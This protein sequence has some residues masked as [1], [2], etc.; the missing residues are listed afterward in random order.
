MRMRCS[1]AGAAQARTVQGVGGPGSCPMAAS[2]R[3]GLAGESWHE[4]HPCCGGPA[5]E[6]GSTRRACKE[7]RPVHELLRTLRRTPDRM[8]HARRRAA[9]LAA[10]RTGSHPSRLLVLCHGNICRSPFAAELVRRELH[11]AGIV[12]ESAGFIG[13]GRSSPIEAQREASNHGVDLSPHRSRLITADMVR[14]ATAVLTMDARQARAVIRTYG[15][16]RRDVLLLGDF[17]PQAVTA[18]AIRDPIDQPADV[19]RLV[20]ARIERC[21]RALAAALTAAAAPTGG[22]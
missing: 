2:E 10:I 7:E 15:K 22:A 12:V 20:Y 18:R 13:P 8:L 6:D 5:I 3:M 1:L 14:T 19:Y 11:A 4:R 16:P 21:A 9:A 17:D